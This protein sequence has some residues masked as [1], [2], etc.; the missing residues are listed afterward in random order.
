[1]I[2]YEIEGYKDSENKLKELYRD[3]RITKKSFD[4]NMKIMKDFYN[5]DGEM[6]LFKIEVDNKGEA[7]ICYAPPMS[8]TY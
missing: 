1:M 3:K 8:M 2:T 7:T 5:E 6:T 4:S